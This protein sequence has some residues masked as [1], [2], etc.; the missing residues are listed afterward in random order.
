MS[1]NIPKAITDICQS[2]TV[3]IDTRKLGPR[4]IVSAR[5]MAM[6]GML[7][8]HGSPWFL[9]KALRRE[10]GLAT[11]HYNRNGYFAWFNMPKNNEDFFNRLQAL[12]VAMELKGAGGGRIY[13]IVKAANDKQDAGSLYCDLESAKQ[14]MKTLE[15]PEYTG[16][17]EGVIS[18]D[19]TSNTSFNY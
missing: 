8:G 12:S 9:A 2:I 4:Q 16:R 7:N 13:D 5:N 17:I 19:V 14:I 3:N 15:L 11:V 6:T 10:A 1:T 18:I